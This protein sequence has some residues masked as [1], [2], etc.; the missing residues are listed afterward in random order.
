MPQW[1]AYT[2]NIQ[3]FLTYLLLCR[4]A[5]ACFCVLITY[6]KLTHN[7]SNVCQ[8]FGTSGIR[9]L[10]HQG[11]TGAWRR[12]IVGFPS[13]LMTDVFQMS[14][15]GSKPSPKGIIRPSI[16]GSSTHWSWWTAKWSMEVKRKGIK[17]PL[18]QKKELF[19]LLLLFKQTLI[20]FS[21]RFPCSP[22][23]KLLGLCYVGD[24]GKPT[25][26]NKEITT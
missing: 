6:T 19:V 26:Q 7:I 11:V 22:R 13:A 15:F 20:H 1:M 14:W 8:S 17:E 3:Y 18:N 4:H 21:K 5:S 2:G 23:V 10:N 12:T 24:K 25:Q 16:S 9:W